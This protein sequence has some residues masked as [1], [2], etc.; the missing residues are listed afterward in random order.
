MAGSV[1]QGLSIERMCACAGVSR[2]GYYRH[3]Q[4]SAPRE[5]ETGVRAFVFDGSGPG[6][7]EIGIVTLQTIG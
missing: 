3:W 5:E 1:P 7:E 4:A 6:A 2:A